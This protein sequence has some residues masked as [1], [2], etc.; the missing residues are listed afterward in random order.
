MKDAVIRDALAIPRLADRL[1]T[2]FSCVRIR[3]A[4][5]EKTSSRKPNTGKTGM[6][7]M[8]PSY[9]EREDI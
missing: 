8:C 9:R 3:V 4:N 1:E 2:V 7:V 5:V 6:E